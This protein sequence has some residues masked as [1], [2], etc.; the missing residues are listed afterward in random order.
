MEAAR[1]ERAFRR[2]PDADHHFCARRHR[3]HQVA[4]AQAALLRDR[5]P[6]REHRCAR[7]RARIR[8]GQIVELER[9]RHRAVRERG[10]RRLHLHA[11]AAQNSAL[12]VRP[13]ALRVRDHGLAPRQLAAVEDHRHRIDDR[14]LD[15]ELHL[16]GDVL[17]AQRGCVLREPDGVPG[18]GRAACAVAPSRPS[19]QRRAPSQRGSPPPRDWA[20]SLPRLRSSRRVP[21]MSAGLR[22]R[23]ASQTWRSSRCVIAQTTQICAPKPIA[24][25]VRPRS[26]FR[27]G[28]LVSWAIQRAKSDAHPTRRSWAADRRA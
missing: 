11:P 24:R 1:F 2:E 26:L 4:S 14:V 22:V 8:I 6:G 7:M 28:G 12:A 17:V 10:R 21:G 3:K 23:L 13:R 18:P 5:E 15:A 27:D 25:R 9:V 19:P 20:P 16:R